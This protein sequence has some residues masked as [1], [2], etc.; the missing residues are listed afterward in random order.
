MAAA[1]ARLGAAGV[2]G[3]A[4]DARLLLADALG[5]PPARLVLVLDDRVG[6]AALAD[7]ERKVAARA[8]FRPVAQILGRRSFWG[9]DFE[10]TADVLDPRPE[11]ETLVA[12]ALEGPAPARILDLGTGS[13]VILVTLLSEWPDARGLGTDTSAAALEV[14]RRNALRHG[15]DDRAAFQQADWAEGCDGTFDLIVCNPPYIPE[16]EIESLARDVRDWEPLG[17]LTAGPSGLESF[18]AI[19]PAL[20]ALLAPGGR[21][22]FEIGSGQGAAVAGILK[23]VGLRGIIVS[24]D[25]DGRDRVVCGVLPIEV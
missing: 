7:F 22:L 24:R 20:C 18:E 13:G 6:S 25:L 5:C 8:R 10:V 17:A 16:G 14:A 2:P 1:A 12:H 4:R 11:T 21:A 23:I 19:A 3:A 15:V 9:R